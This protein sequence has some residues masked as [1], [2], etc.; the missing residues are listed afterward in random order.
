MSIRSFETDLRSV[1]ERGRSDERLA[2]APAH[3]PYGNARD[4][5][6]M[7][8]AVAACFPDTGLHVGDLAWL[9]RGAH[10]HVDLRSRIDLWETADRGVRG[11][12]FLRPNGGFNLL[13]DSSYA[14]AGQIDWM[15]DVVQAHVADAEAAGDPPVALY[16][17]G[18][19][20]E[21]SPTDRIASASGLSG[22]GLLLRLPRAAG[23]SRWALQVS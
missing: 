14:D 3:R 4:L 15:L 2:P 8:M 22:A 1:T 21:H 13:I 18:L 7:Q 5:R 12:T 11:W 6:G 23:S 16:T 19:D 17:Y 10:D 9:N 20:T